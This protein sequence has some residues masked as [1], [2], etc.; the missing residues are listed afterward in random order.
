MEKLTA[1]EQAII[2]TTLDCFPLKRA[3]TSIKKQLPESKLEAAEKY[4]KT[5]LIKF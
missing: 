3:L 5:Y 1:Y 2:M 4:I